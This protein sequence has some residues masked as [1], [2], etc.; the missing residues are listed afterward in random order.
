M[1]DINQVSVTRIYQILKVLQNNRNI[2]EVLKYCWGLWN[3]RKQADYS[4]KDK[5]IQKGAW[6][7]K[8]MTSLYF[9]Y[10][11]F[12][13]SYTAFQ[14]R[15]QHA[16]HDVWLIRNDSN[17]VHGDFNCIHDCLNFSQSKWIF[18][19]ISE[20]S[21]VLKNRAKRLFL[22]HSDVSVSIFPFLLIYPRAKWC[23]YT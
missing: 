22:N 13:T 14:E 10:L 19:I 1:E 23:T 4:L 20:S 15:L 17:G 9:L 2:V 12:N 21:P 16:L 7:Q 8:G 5:S 11:A 3:K 6:E 18:P